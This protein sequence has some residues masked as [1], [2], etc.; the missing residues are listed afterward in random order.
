MFNME[1]STA[2]ETVQKPLILKEIEDTLQILYPNLSKNIISN[3]L[4]PKIAQMLT[5]KRITFE[6]A[7]EKKI[8]NWFSLIFLKSGGGK[9]RLAN[10]IERFVFP[11]FQQWFFEK[12]TEMYKI[13]QESSTTQTE[14]EEKTEDKG[15][16]NDNTVTTTEYCPF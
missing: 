6:E 2:A 9:D 16:K 10:D 3:T 15:E 11:D 13:A 14:T 8:P 12:S 5:A 7:G 4:I 1:N